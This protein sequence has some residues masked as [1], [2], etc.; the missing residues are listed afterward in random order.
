M[1]EQYLEKVE[2]R[3]RELG[4]SLDDKNIWQERGQWPIV[5]LLRVDN[6][7]WAREKLMRAERSIDA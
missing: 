6:A 4:L 7:I 5:L 1:S 2:R 3:A